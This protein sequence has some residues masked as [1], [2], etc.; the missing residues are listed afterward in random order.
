VSK[1]T[2]SF[3]GRVLKVFPVVQ[4]DM[5]IGSDPQCTVHI[6][7]LAVQPRHARLHTEGADS[8]LFDQD[9]PDGTFVNQQRIDEQPL[10]DGAIIRIGKHTL[11]FSFEEMLES[12]MEEPAPVPNGV[13]AGAQTQPAAEPTAQPGAAT[14][15][16][17]PPPTHE[18][19]QAWLQIMSGQNLGK[20]LSLHRA[21]TNL[22]KTGVVTA[23]IAR[24]SEGYFISHLEGEHPTRV[25]D[26]P[27]GEKARKLEDGDFIQ[28]GNVKMQFYYE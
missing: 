12:E 5:Y 18:N 26:E 3:K 20:T 7:S 25:A 16:A 15:S 9:T 10:K 27:L 8:V 21:M 6:D 2:L 22:G 19:R 28:I 13:A 23:V 14:E 4:G 11:T 24:R 17:P 1:L